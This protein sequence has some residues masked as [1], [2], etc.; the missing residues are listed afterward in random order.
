M[1]FYDFVHNPSWKIVPLKGPK[2]RWM[3]G[4]NH[5]HIEPTN[6]T[7]DI[8]KIPLMYLLVMTTNNQ[9]MVLIMKQCN[10]VSYKSTTW[11]FKTFN[12]HIED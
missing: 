8:P 12:P 10:G 5:D 3:V 4:H 9:L 2:F 7:K 1:F 11:H 6:L